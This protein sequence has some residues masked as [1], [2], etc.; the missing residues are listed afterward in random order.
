ASP[1]I[2]MSDSTDDLADRVAGWMRPHPGLDVRVADP[3]TGTALTPG[4][5]GELQV[6]GWCVMQGYYRKPEAA[7][8]AFTGDGDLRPGALGLARS[9]VR[10]RFVG[11]L[12][13]I[14]RVGGENVAPTDI[15][16]VLHQHPK[17]R[18]VQ[19]FALPDPRL[20]E[21][22]GAYIVAREGEELTV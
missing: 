22:P 17:I 4:S 1:N 12:K 20:I 5:E 13:E 10:I 19:A 3:A 15:E 6:R 18:Q 8:E 2:T 16:N 7:A 11:R 14:I 9:D 21:V